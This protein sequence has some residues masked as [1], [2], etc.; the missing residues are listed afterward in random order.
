MNSHD[1]L[2]PARSAASFTHGSLTWHRSCCGSCSSSVSPSAVSSSLH[3]LPLVVLLS[4]LWA[5]PRTLDK[6]VQLYSSLG[7]DVAV[8]HTP[9]LPLWIPSMADSNALCVLDELEVELRASGLRPV[10]F[11]PF[12]GACKVSLSQSLMMLLRRVT[13]F[14]QSYTFLLLHCE[15]L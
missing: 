13:P 14:L 15:Q 3:P 6:Y 1:V 7:F 11:A 8:F 5:H 9:A 4:W 2:K 12:S 10:V